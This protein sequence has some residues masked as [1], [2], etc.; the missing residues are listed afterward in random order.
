MIAQLS[1]N[2]L[3]HIIPAKQPLIWRIVT[4]NWLPFH[5]GSRQIKKKNVKIH[6]PF[7]PPPPLV[8]EMAIFFLYP[9]RSVFCTWENFFQLKKWKYLEKFLRIFASFRRDIKKKKECERGQTPTPPCM[10]FHTLFSK[11]P[12]PSG[13]CRGSQLYSGQ[14]AGGDT[15]AESGQHHVSA[16]PVQSDDL[17]CRHQGHGGGDQCSVCW[18]ELHIVTGAGAF[19]KTSSSSSTTNN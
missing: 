1:S 10:N 8:C 11:W 2:H 15:G 13:V 17:G 6:P 18:G 16:P 19:I 4:H 5:K 12:I 7:R 3:L 9:L 14:W